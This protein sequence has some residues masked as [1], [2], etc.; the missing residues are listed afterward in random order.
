MAKT[1]FSILIIVP[2]IG[3]SLAA[4]TLGTNQSISYEETLFSPQ[5]VVWVANRDNPLADQNGVLRFSNVSNMVVLKQLNGVVW[6]SKLSRVLKNPVAQLLDSRNLLWDKSSS[7]ADEAYSWQNFDY[8]TDTLLPG[9]KLGLNLKTGLERRLI[10]WK[11]M[12]DPSPG[13]YIH[14][15][16]CRQGLPQHEVVQE[17]LQRKILRTGQW[18]GV[19]FVGGPIMP[20]V[21]IVPMFANN[22]A[23]ISFMLEVQDNRLFVKMTLHYLGVTQLLVVNRSTSATWNVKR[24]FPSD[25]CDTYG[26][27]GANA[28]CNISSCECVK[29]FMPNSPDKWGSLDFSGGCKRIIHINCSKGDCFLEIKHVKLPDLLAFALNKSMSLSECEDKCLRNCSCTAYANSDVRS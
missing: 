2:A 1:A 11:S 20:S 13:D 19:Q 9:M 16:N 23:E 10:A 25:P 29:G 21:A 8:L 27:C 18:N 26:R 7:S 28:I 6:S 3:L 12:N 17:D 24:E 22:E 4:N 14:A 5:T 15:L